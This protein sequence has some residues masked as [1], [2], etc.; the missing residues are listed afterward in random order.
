[1]KRKSILLLCALMS[2]GAFAQKSLVKDVEKAIGGMNPDVKTLKAACSDIL[3]ALVN[4][5]TKDD[6]KTW[7]VAGKANF[8][9]FDSQQTKMMMKQPVDTMM[10]GDALIKG[11]EYFVK[12]LP[13]DSVKEVDKKTGEYKLNKDGSIKIKTSKVSKEIANSLVT[14]HNDFSVM[15]SL[16]YDS[17]HYK[18]AAKAWGIYAAIPYAGIV[19]RDKFAVPDTVIGQMEFYQ[20]TASWQAEDLKGAVAAFASAR[21]HGYKAKEAYDYALSCAAGLQDNDAIVAIAAEAYEEFGN[22]DIQYMNILINDKLNKEKFDEAE[23]LI[24]KA[25]ASNPNNPELINLQGLI[26]ENKKDEA[27]AKALFIQVT[28]LKPD[29]AQGQFNAGRIIMKEAIALQ[30]DMEKMAPAEY[31]KVKES[32]LIPLFKEALPYMEEAYRLDNTNT[33]AKNILRNLYYQLGDE[34]KLNALEQY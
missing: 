29:Y 4:A 27:G 1:M 9:L 5:E 12:A 8:G 13:L 15:A 14:R 10:M 17:K 21:L 16:L 32:Q 18:E 28:K 34:A 2:F 26:L 33:N 25:L 7:L 24:N 22:K 30:K 19:D 11:Y 3:P 20:G 31:Q 23:S 6:A